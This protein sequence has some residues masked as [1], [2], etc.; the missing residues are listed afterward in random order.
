MKSHEQ[1]G[2]GFFP[3]HF[4]MLFENVVTPLLV[5]ED[6]YYFPPIAAGSQLHFT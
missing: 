5:S 2:L 6:N 3:L 1:S 4:P